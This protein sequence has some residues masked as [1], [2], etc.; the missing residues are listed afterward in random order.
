MSV[1][2][3]QE[4][5][6]LNV[7]RI[8]GLL[9]KSELDTAQKEAASQWKDSVGHKVL[10]IIESFKGWEKSEDWGDMTFY[11]EYRDKIAKIAIVGDPK[12]EAEMMMFA[13]AG[14]RPSPVRYFAPHQ[15]EQAR[16]WLLS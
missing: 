14:F 2:I 8:S 6:N 1:T 9:R 10:V 7:M 13:G 4:N 12:L 16:Q 3:H 11:I 5:I 15:M